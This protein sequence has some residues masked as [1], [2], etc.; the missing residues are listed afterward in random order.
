[1]NFMPSPNQYIEDCVKKF[2]EKFVKQGIPIGIR[3]FEAKDG[4][5]ITPS[6]IKLYLT[7]SL[8]GLLELIEKWMHENAAHPQNVINDGLKKG[9]MVEMV[10]TLSDLS[11][12]LK[13][14]K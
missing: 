14:I 12:W 6:K 11:T 4:L 13:S 9:D 2:D 8:N 5:D 1:M 10:V 7:S 3:K